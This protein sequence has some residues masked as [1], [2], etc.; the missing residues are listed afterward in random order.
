MSEATSFLTI[1]DFSS[2]GGTVQVWAHSAD[3]GRRT[4]IASYDPQNFPG[5]RSEARRNAVLRAK[6]L[7]EILG[8][9]YR[10]EAN[11]P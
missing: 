8:V 4:A 11:T 10:P 1:V 6:E 2:S 3:G 7:A 5:G 9:E